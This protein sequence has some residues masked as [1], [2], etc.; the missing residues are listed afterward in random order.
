[1]AKKFSVDKWALKKVRLDMA[2]QFVPDV[3]I[4]NAADADGRGILLQVTIDG[5]PADLE[6]M[7][8]CLAWGHQNGNQDLSR[9][10]AVDASKGLFKLYY[11]PAMM[12][13]G[14]VTARVSIFAGGDSPITGSR[15]FTIHVER[16]PIDEDR[17][18]SDESFSEFK[19]A[20]DLL[21]STNNR[22]EE[23]EEARQIA[24]TARNTAEELR[25]RHEDAR[26]AAENERLAAE[27]ER[28]AAELERLAAEAEREAAEEDRSLAE[29]ARVEAEAYR[30]A[31]FAEIEQRSKGWL[32]YYCADGE[33]DAATR[34]PVIE[35]PDT[36]TL[37]FVPEEF[38]TEDGQWVEWMWDAQGGRWEKL[39][40]SQ[41]TFEPITADQMDAIVAGNDADEGGSEVMT[42][43]GLR[44]WL[45]KLRGVFAALVHVH[46]ASDI[47]SGTFGTSRIANDAVTSEK[48]APAVRDSLS[49]I[50]GTKNDLTKKSVELL[51]PSQQP[52]PLYSLVVGASGVGVWRGGYNGAD[53][54]YEWRVNF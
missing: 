26:V 50:E 5:E 14:D 46:S 31:T 15:D 40:T 54:A 38:P 17:A 10:E 16:N 9:F 28:D 12:Y 7:P 52:G 45:T 36:S 11:P 34:E 4:G 19:R 2:D 6:G 24:E 3:L 29:L 39:G 8:V 21:Y 20:A 13:P 43:W 41:A 47:T 37:Y 32:R 44:Y 48:L 33:W 51:L 42:R 1:M 18:L 49:R 53:G 25:G 27:L 35:N 22:L 30:T 23:A